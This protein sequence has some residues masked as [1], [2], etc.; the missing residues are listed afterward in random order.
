MTPF[1]RHRFARGRTYPQ[2]ARSNDMTSTERRYAENLRLRELAGEVLWWKFQGIKLRLADQTF[3][4][5]DFDVQ[6]ADGLLELHEMKTT[7]KQKGGGLRVGIEEDAAVKL[8]VAAEQYPLFRFVLAI[9][10]RDGAGTS[11]IFKT[12]GEDS[13]PQRVERPAALFTK[14]LEGGT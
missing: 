12:I 2:G 14:P 6:L 4:T 10:C 3:F 9:E 8:K 5:P 7:W 11:W 13:I 1:R